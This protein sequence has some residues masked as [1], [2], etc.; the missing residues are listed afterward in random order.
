MLKRRKRKLKIFSI[1]NKFGKSRKRKA[2]NKKTKASE[3]YDVIINIE[4]DKFTKE[5]SIEASIEESLKK[6]KE[7]SIK[8]STSNEGAL[9]INT[10]KFSQNNDNNDNSKND[11]NKDNHDL[12]N[13]EKF[14]T[15]AK[16]KENREYV[17]RIRNQVKEV[18]QENY[19]DSIDNLFNQFENSGYVNKDNFL[20]RLIF[21]ILKKYGYIDIIDDNGEIDPNAIEQILKSIINDAYKLMNEDNNEIKLENNSVYICCGTEKSCFECNQNIFDDE[22]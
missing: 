17:E 16:N 20:F 13:T 3:K 5:K 19:D 9:E 2:H 4:N 7:K 21:M 12:A 15:K 11:D 14:R 8:A 18:L 1:F 22:D 10:H 6:S